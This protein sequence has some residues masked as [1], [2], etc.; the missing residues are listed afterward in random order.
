MIATI[1]GSYL[2]GTISAIPSKSYAHRIA[3]CNFLSGA[4]ITVCKDFSSND[5]DVTV[6]C[7]ENIRRG[8]NDL[9]V[10][11]SGSTLRFLLPLC[12]VLG[13]KYSFTGHGKLMQRPNDELFAVM[14][15]HGI[16][17]EQTEKI[18]IYGKLTS[19]KYEI[20]GDI[21]SQYISGLLMA[22]PF[23]D[24]DSEIVLTTPLCSAPYVEITL[25]VLKAFGIVVER[26]LNGF[27]VLGNQKYNG[28]SAVE[29][30]WS[31]A[32]FFLVGAAI[33]G[34]VTISGLNPDS[35]Q[36]D[37]FILEILRLAGV[38]VCVNKKGVTVKKSEIKN[39]EFSASDCP[40]LVPIA[41]VLAAFAN[42]K[43]V[44]KDVERLKIKE[45]DRIESAMAMLNGF[46]I[47]ANSDGKSFIVYGGNPVCGKAD[48]FNDH[49]LAMASSI[50]ALGVQGVS[51]I[52]GANAVNKSY[53]TFYD[54]CQKLGGVVKY[55]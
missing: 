55:V 4:S 16:K 22:L 35:V 54:D 45:S 41:A 29:G 7:L 15:S 2:K 33:N 23:L 49:R 13:G 48:S 3:I 40:D 51:T 50:L 53:P 9:D 1:E 6:A 38:D 44:I 10:G 25:Q 18:Y 17:I 43:S 27:K 8:V 24:G 37:K 30:D 11:E 52:T 47:N 39:F 46:G 12:A 21:S 26:T 14:R 36:G 42:G 31:N 20:R 19:G 28:N 32:A 34:E 5:I